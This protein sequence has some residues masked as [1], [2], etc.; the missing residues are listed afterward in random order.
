MN[1]SAT[2]KEIL[3]LIKAEEKRQ[4]T[5]LQMIPSENFTSKAVMEAVGSVLMNKYTEGYIGKRYYQGAKYYDDIEK[6]AIDRAKKLFNVEYV[7]VQPYSGSPA[8]MA[9]YF[10]LLNQGDT[11]LGLSLPFG[12]HLTHG[13]PEVTFSGKYFRTI[14]YT[15]DKTGY[16]NYTE[17]EDLTVKLKPKII[18]SGA[19]AYPRTIDFKTIGHIADKV[20]AYHMADIS[21]IAGLVAGQAHVSPVD[22]AHIVTTTTHKTLRGPRGAMIMV[23]KKGLDKDMDLPS[24]IDKAVFPGLQGGPHN[25]TTAAIAVALEEA[26]RAEFKR[27][28]K[29]VVE[30]AKALAAA[31]NMHG[32]NLLTEGTDN[33]LILVDLS[34]K[35][36][37][38]WCGAWALEYAGITVNRNS[39]PFDMKSAFYPSGIRLGTP[40]I[41]TQGLKEHHMKLIAQYINDVLEVCKNYTTP[42]MDGA[43]RAKFKT[44]VSRDKTIKTIAKEV[45]T[46]LKT[47]V[48]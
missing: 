10:A 33:H 38:G 16:I 15:T 26:S 36:V 9:V 1:L 44:K 5:T 47:L 23:T 19:T 11:L 8:N 37:D 22:Y 27:Y 30:N 21:H 18:I 6:L 20:G 14:Q 32:F 48:P 2:D 41:T 29:Q 4:K 3:K 12:G 43:T 42:N 35:H 28:A 7:N 40:A 13:H 31:L 46:L 17:L 25:N 39:V 24:K 45:S 34:N